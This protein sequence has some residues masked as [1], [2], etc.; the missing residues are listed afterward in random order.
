MREL[1]TAEA[2]NV[3]GG[4][5]TEEDVAGFLEG[6]GIGLDFGGFPEFGI[7]IEVA[8]ALMSAPSAR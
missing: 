6:F 4:D 7:P 8:G 5:N 2:K 1:T 3:S